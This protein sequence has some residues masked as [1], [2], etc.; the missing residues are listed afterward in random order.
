MQKTKTDAG[1]SIEY[2]HPWMTPMKQAFAVLVVACALAGCSTTPVPFDQAKPIPVERV[3]AFGAKPSVPYGTIVVA[4]DTGFIAGG[5]FVSVH[6]D[7]KQ[8]ARIDTGEVVSLYVPAGDHLVGL[9]ADQQ[10]KGM[11]DWGVAL[12]E[13]TANIRD[14][15]VK[16]FRI[17]GDSNTGLDIRPS[18]I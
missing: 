4:R 1:A 7:G 2:S 13:Q 18:S 17:G 14:G 8:A 9:G 3:L 16:R 15:Q 11:C 5:C 10:G 6:V 12:K